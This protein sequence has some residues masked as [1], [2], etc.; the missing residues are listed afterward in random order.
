M[1]IAVLR[2]V[3]EDESRVALLPD[4]VGKLVKAAGEVVVERGAGAAAGAADDAYAAAGAQL[5]AD[6]SRACAAAALVAK[7]QPPTLDEAS[8]LEPGCVLVSLLPVAQRADLWPAL[9]GRRV[10]A[11][12]LER[13]PRIARAQSMDVLSSQATVAGYKAVLLGAAALP[14]LLPMLTTAAG[15]IP[16]AKAFVLG[17]G[18]AGLQAI[19]TARR[20]GAVVS[21]FDVR[22]A[23]REQV[24]SLGARFV[25]AEIASEEAQDRGGYAKAQSES[26]RRQT[27]AALDAH[28]KD[29][30]LVVSTAAIPGRRAPVLITAEMVRGM[31]HGAV[32]VDL[33]AETGGN[34]EIT[35]PGQTVQVGGVT[36]L[37]PLNL[38]SSIP[39]HAS[40]MLSRNIL[41]LLQHL[42]PDGELRVDVA[43]E[44]TGAMAV[45]HAGEIRVAP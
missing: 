45:I 3:A 32:I 4:A 15:S 12:A 1:R 42:L 27:L 2:E 6:A 22:A 29:V 44:I 8:R 25:A 41:A 19:A 20:L 35:R 36:I 7:V 11:L 5:A 39:V 17:A 37:G 23:A 31:K 34:C 10:T 18:V 30:D 43:D 33:A 9:A 26:E 38:P 13:V 28:L 21:A 24:E 16:P 40:Q 14:R